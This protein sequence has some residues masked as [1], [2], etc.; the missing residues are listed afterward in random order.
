M[1]INVRAG[2][3]SNPRLIDLGSDFGTPNLR[4]AKQN[5]QTYANEGTPALERGS[6][7]SSTAAYQ[8]EMVPTNR[9]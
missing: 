2:F 8:C 5:G 4:Q 3:C 1:C 6:M 7:I 9:K